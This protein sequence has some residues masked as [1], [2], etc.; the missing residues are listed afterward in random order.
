MIL[1]LINFSLA[2]A[3]LVLSAFNFQEGD[4]FWGVL[5]FGMFISNLTVAVV[6]I[7]KELTYG[8]NTKIHKD[9]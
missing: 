3:L 4:I 7:L 8:Y 2:L 6:C 9:V 5:Y 1:S